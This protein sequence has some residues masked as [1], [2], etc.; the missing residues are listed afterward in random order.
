M[1]ITEFYR[2]RNDGV[3]LF[4]TFSNKNKYIRKVGTNKE[5]EEAIDVE[6]SGFEYE[7]TD[8]EIKEI[9]EPLNLELYD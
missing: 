1:I 6:N 4:K 7:E 3:R 2:T 9:V 8:K 5:Y